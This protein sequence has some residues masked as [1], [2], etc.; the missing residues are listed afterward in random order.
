MTRVRRM[1]WNDDEGVWGEGE[2]DYPSWWPKKN[3]YYG[4]TH[5]PRL[6]NLHGFPPLTPWNIR[7]NS[8]WNGLPKF[9]VEDLPCPSQ[10]MESIMIDLLGFMDRWERTFASDSVSIQFVTDVMEDLAN[11]YDDHRKEIELY[12]SSNFLLQI[13]FFGMDFDYWGVEKTVVYNPIS[14]PFNKSLRDRGYLPGKWI[15]MVNCSLLMVIADDMRR[16]SPRRENGKLYIE[17]WK[18]FSGNDTYEKSGILPLPF[19]PELTIPNSNVRAPMIWNIRKPE[20]IK[21]MMDNDPYTFEQLIR[22]MKETD[23]KN[24]NPFWF[25]DA[26]TMINGNDGLIKITKLRKMLTYEFDNH[27]SKIPLFSYHSIDPTYDFF[28]PWSRPLPMMEWLKYILNIIKADY[29][30][31]IAADI[32]AKK[33]IKEKTPLTPIGPPIIIPNP[34][35][36]SSSIEWSDIKPVKEETFLPWDDVKPSKT[37]REIVEDDKEGR[38][39]YDDEKSKIADYALPKGIDIPNEWEIAKRKVAPYFTPVREIWKKTAQWKFLTE[40]VQWPLNKNSFYTVLKID[41]KSKYD[42]D[43]LNVAEF[44][45]YNPIPKLKIPPFDWKEGERMTKGW[46]ITADAQFNNYLEWCLK[47]CSSKFSKLYKEPGADVGWTR[48]ELKQIG[49][50]SPYKL[51]NVYSD[52]GILNHETQ[53]ESF[54]RKIIRVLVFPVDLLDWMFG[55]NFWDQLKTTVISTFNFLLEVFDVIIKTIVDNWSWLLPLGVIIFGGYVGTIVLKEKI[56]NNV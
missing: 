5:N 20:M 4:K 12:V 21:Q 52:Y 42:E 56:K 25:S 3:I 24:R 33:R 34:N 2:K 10:E 19:K 35:P 50:N 46:V 6:E 29:L 18:S 40:S 16:T 51:D 17:Y 38:K 48:D 37:A 13:N 39:E 1:I 54:V 47:N 49:V 45:L 7:D 8:Y 9:S 32:I 27:G 55:D 31:L 15:L 43:F 30:E 36:T 22:Y 26:S 14:L 23:T 28:K 41:P 53:F 11:Y 44:M